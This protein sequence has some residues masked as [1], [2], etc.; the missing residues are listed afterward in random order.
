MSSI[1]LPIKLLRA[2]ITVIDLGGYTKASKVLHCS[3][4]AISLQIKRL[5]ELLGEKLLVH[6]GGRVEL[7][8]HGKVLAGFARQTLQLNDEAVSRFRRGSIEGALR[9][10]LP[11][12]YAVAF[13]QGAVTAFAIENRSVDLSIHCDISQ[14][15]LDDL[16][17]DRLDIVVALIDNIERQNL[18]RA[19]EEQ[20]VWVCAAGGSAHEQRPVPLVTHPEGCEY[21][22]RIVETLN[23]A[24]M[25]WRIAY[26]SP[27]ISGLQSAVVADLGVSALTR[28]TLKDGIRVLGRE[29]GFPDL[30]KIKIGL[31]YKHPL[32]SDAGLSLVKHLIASL[33]DAA[34]GDFMP[35]KHLM[36][37]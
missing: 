2:F 25:D 24:G 4:P 34:D 26:S 27:G 30:M 22:L 8:S 36:A 23:D 6:S 16:D 32:Q 17:A 7:T 1:D 18:V 21:R 28:K 9:V 14:K 13:L 3:Q 12:D 19:W 15:L 5:E 20:P 10:G 33:D 37:S 31:F 11:T 35:S 29:D